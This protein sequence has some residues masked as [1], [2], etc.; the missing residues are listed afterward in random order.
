MVNSQKSGKMPSLPASDTN[1]YQPRGYR[2]GPF[3]FE[4]RSG[5]IRKHGVRLRVRKQPVQVLTILLEHSGEVV[6]RED[7]RSAL[8]PDNTVVEFDHGINTAIQRLRDVL[9]D[10]ADEPRYIETLAG[11]GY[12]F[13]GGA[14]PLVPPAAPM[15]ES[16]VVAPPAPRG[17]R[18]GKV[19]VTAAVVMLAVAAGVGFLAPREPARNLVFPLGAG[20]DA[21]PSPDGSAIVYRDERGLVLR[22]MDSVTE[23]TLYS[24]ATLAD[25]PMWSPDGSQVLIRSLAGLY[26]IPV[27]NGPPVMIWPANYTTRGYTW[28]PGGDILLAVHQEGIAQGLYLIPSGSSSPLRLEIPKLTGGLFYEPEFLPEGGRFLFTWATDGNIE[29]GIIWQP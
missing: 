19:A 27:P 3:E 18:I 26:R 20:R 29:A 22:R 7:I 11:R 6:L 4:I 24:A 1:Q 28:G 9:G 21:T 16:A 17:R 23:T 10:S 2:F 15:L 13:I 14:Q 25:R 12:R 5:E 8:W